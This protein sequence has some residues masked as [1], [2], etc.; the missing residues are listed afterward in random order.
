VPGL[1]PARLRRNER[2]FAALTALDLSDDHRRRLF[3]LARGTGSYTAA[4]YR[5][6]ED[7]LL[8]Y[9]EDEKIPAGIRASAAA[10]GKP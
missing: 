8:R 4:D 5:R 3:A 6:F 9:A 7:L 1:T 10:T 2:I